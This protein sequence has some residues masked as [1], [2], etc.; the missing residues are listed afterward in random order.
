MAATLRGGETQQQRTRHCAAIPAC[1]CQQS[2]SQSRSLS[3]LVAKA[4]HLRELPRACQSRARPGR[5]GRCGKHKSGRHLCVC[6]CVWRPEHGVRECWPRAAGMRVLVTRGCAI[7]I[8][9]LSCFTVRYRVAIL[10]A[11]CGQGHLT[12]TTSPDTAQP[13]GSVVDPVLAAVEA[14]TSRA[15]APAPAPA[16]P[17]LLAPLPLAV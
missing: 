3:W 13:L 16:P 5:Q 15:P 11:A 10:A 14:A 9:S 8:E 17:P 7:P 2:L 1:V 12:H 4:W 6:V